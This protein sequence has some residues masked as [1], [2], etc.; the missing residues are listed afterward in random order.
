MARPKEDRL[1]LLRATRTN[2]SPVYALVGDTG[3]RFTRALNDAPVHNAAA[4]RDIVGQEHRVAAIT[5][6]EAIAALRDSLADAPLYI[7]DGHHRYET[8]LAYQAERPD[9]PAAGW[10]LMAVSAADD[11]GLLI[12]PIHRIVRPRRGAE[13]LEAGLRSTFDIE[14]AGPMDVSTINRVQSTLLASASGL[15]LAALGVRP[16]RIL[17]LR[18]RDRSAVEARMPAERAPAWKALAVNVL[19]YGILEPLLGIDADALQAGEHVEFTEDAAEAAQAVRDG[20]APLAFLVPATRADE[21]IAVADAGD[22]MPQKS[23]YFYPKLGT[24]LVLN[25]HDIL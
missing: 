23:T 12:L 20:R 7:A 11:P 24:G 16:E 8:A 9:D 14:D 21:M 10:I 5:D 22:R 18:L 15:S 4:G 6:P 2:I 13:D 3:H 17:V 19:Q 1:A 25:A